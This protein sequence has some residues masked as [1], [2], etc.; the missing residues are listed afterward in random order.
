[1]GFL[2]N[3]LLLKGGGDGDFKLVDDSAPQLGG[4]LDINGYSITG[5]GNI[6]INGEVTADTL[7]GAL[8]GE[9]C[10]QAK[11]GEA[12]TKGQPV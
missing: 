6:D 2:L 11:A 3:G 4:N 12:I 10:F 1:M 7:I 5:T 8:R 9:V